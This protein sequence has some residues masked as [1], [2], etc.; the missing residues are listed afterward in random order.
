M[1]I[2]LLTITAF[3]REQYSP[4]GA[5]FGKRVE[6][7]S[8]FRGFVA[9]VQGLFGGQIEMVEKKIQDVVEGAKADFMK[10]L[11][12]Q[13]PEA[14]FVVGFQIH[15]SDVG[16]DD[17]NQF[18]LATVQGTAVGPKK[19]VLR[20][21]AKTRKGTRKMK[22]SGLPTDY[23]D[24][25]HLYNESHTYPSI[26]IALK[27][28]KKLNKPGPKQPYKFY[29]CEEVQDKYGVRGYQGKSCENPRFNG[30][31][32]PMKQVDKK[33]EAQDIQDLEDWCCPR[34]NTN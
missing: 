5:V 12:L 1:S 24:C 34:E 3:N 29:D 30:M 31:F 7:M 27:K 10:Q 22:G 13:Y 26:C 17:K 18:I 6:A 21:G 16:R 28:P 32:I 19:S 8:L 14:K 25:K 20:G 23:S 4:L 9:G 2:P 15:I 11:Q 33:S